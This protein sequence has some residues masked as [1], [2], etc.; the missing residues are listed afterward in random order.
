MSQPVGPPQKLRRLPCEQASESIRGKKL[1]DDD[2]VLSAR[3]CPASERTNGH[4]GSLPIASG[5]VCVCWRSA[6]EARALDTSARTLGTASHTH[7]SVRF[8]D[9]DAVDGP[10]AL[11]RVPRV[12]GG[13]QQ[14]HHTFAG[15]CAHGQQTARGQRQAPPQPLARKRGCRISEGPPP[16]SVAAFQGAADAADD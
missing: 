10:V 2:C 1:P 15:T 6:E 14:S 7:F 4:T 16:D 8:G 13:A 12:R 3:P 5:W 9:K 11:A